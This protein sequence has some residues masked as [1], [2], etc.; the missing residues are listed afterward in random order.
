MGE[1]TI[2]SNISDGAFCKNSYRFS[3]VFKKKTLLQVLSCEYN[4]FWIECKYNNTNMIEINIKH[5]YILLYFIQFTLFHLVQQAH[6]A[7]HCHGRKDSEASV[8]RCS[9]KQVFL[10]NWQYLYENTSVGTSL[11]KKDPNTGVVL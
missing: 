3:V 5:N 2:Q 9:R 4:C 10:K 7:L 8:P 1:F 11:L 6:V